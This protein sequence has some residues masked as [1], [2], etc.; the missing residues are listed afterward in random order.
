MRTTHFMIAVIVGSLL[1]GCGTNI[2]S[3]LV[4]ADPIDAALVYLEQD[5]PDS[6]IAILEDVVESE[7]TNYEAKSILALA[8]GQK[9]GLEPLEFALNLATQSS[10]QAGSGLTSMMGALPA[11]T[12][13]NIAGIQ[14]AV[15]YMESIPEASRNKADT[16]KLSMFQSALLTLM[17]KKLDDDLSGEFDASELANLSDEDA[18]AIMLLLANAVTSS[19]AGADGESSAGAASQLAAIQSAIDGESGSSD[20]EKLKNYLSST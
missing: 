13:A 17:M 11:A 5:D 15:T 2:A 12:D 19:N 4:D 7:P 10:E 14:Q 18:A 9:Y 8:I 20:S 16:F 3:S 6:A 1:L